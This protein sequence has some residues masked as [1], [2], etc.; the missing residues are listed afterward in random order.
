MARMEDNSV[1]AIVTDPPYG[2]KFMGKKWDHDVPGVDIWRECLRVLKPGGHLL[3]FAGTRTQHRMA[4]AIEDAGFEIRDMLAWVYGCLSDDTEILIE[5]K[6]ERFNKSIDGKRALC[7]NIDKNLYEW[8]QIQ[9]VVEYAYNDTAFQIRGDHTDQIVSRNHRCIV[10]RGGKFTFQLAETLE[11]EARVPILESVQDLLEAFPVRNK[12]AGAAESV[13]LPRVCSKGRT[14]KE[15]DG[16]T[17]GTIGC[18]CGLRKRSMETGCMVEKSKTTF[19]LEKVQRNH[20]L[21]GIDQAFKQ[22]P[23]RMDSGKF[24]IIQGKNDRSGKS[25]VERRRDVLQQT[26]KLQADQV[27]SMSCGIPSNGAPGWICHGTPLDRGAGRREVPS[28]VGSCASS[29]S[30][31]AEQPFG[32][33]RIVREQSGSQTIRGEGITGSDLATV[34]P[35]HYIGKVWCVRVPFGAF[36]ARRNGKIFITG[37]SGFP[38]STD[39]SKMIDKAAGAEREVVGK[40]RAGISARSRDGDMVGGMAIESEKQ[41]DITAPATDLARQWAGWGSALKPSLEPV[42]MA[43]KPFKGTLAGNVTTWGTGGINVEACRVGTEEWT[44]PGSNAENGIY[45][46]FKNDAARSAVG[47]F[48]AN[49]IHDGSDEVVGLFPES[50]GRNPQGIKVNNSAHDKADVYS[51][52]WKEPSLHAFNDSGSAARFFKCFEYVDNACLFCYTYTKDSGGES[53]KNTHV[54]NAEN[55][56]WNIPETTENIAQKNADQT[57]QKKIVR[58]VK[59]AGNLCDSCAMNFVQEL[60]KIKNLDLSQ[61]ESQVIQDF[62]V[63]YKKCTLLL[64][65]VRYAEAMDNIDTTPITKSLLK[66]FGSVNHAIIRCTKEIKKSESNRLIYV[67]KASRAER[68]LGLDD[69]PIRS[70]GDACDREDGADGLNSPRAGAGR[71]G[72]VRN[73]HPT[74]KPIALMRYLCKLVTP[75]G[76][77]VYDPFC[78][79]GTTLIGAKLEGFRWVGSEMDPE[80][81]TIARKRV[82][83]VVF[84]EQMD[85]FPSAVRQAGL[86][87]EVET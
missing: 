2:L 58:F 32:K 30:R 41:V 34:T 70:G 71:N 52:G 22:G 66:L 55:N 35:I 5:G 33:P 60:V 47:R 51:G 44:H 86:F 8:Q 84:M 27:R 69:L 65:L 25:S 3:A 83:A 24:R 26:R 85:L 63:N 45:G 80:Y 62:I 14:K 67:T 18:M 9:E 11:Q 15:T 46:D 40:V 39:V 23:L 50:D 19:V 57:Q 29:G 1:D 53:C 13:L 77:L 68:D 10:E 17:Q 72:R 54:N 73:F 43:R 38:K 49:L 28:Q 37:N 12:R 7:Y 76:G 74:V 48:P 78:G 21:K 75:P 16:R 31:S 6:W 56:L 64:N 42:T 36:V 61:E 82:D 4:C 79:S 59:S 20:A 81:A 87:E